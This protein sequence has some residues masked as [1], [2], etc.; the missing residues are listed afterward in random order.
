M[1][2]TRIRQSIASVQQGSNA[3]FISGLVVL[4]VILIGIPYN[5]KGVALFLLLLVPFLFGIRLARR[6][7]EQSIGYLLRNALAMGLTMALMVLLFM[8]L[9]NR[10]QAK[11]I[12]VRQYFYNVTTDT[13]EVLS[14]VPARELHPHPPTDPLTGQTQEVTYI[15]PATGEKA[16][17]EAPLT[18]PNDV[19]KKLLAQINLAEGKNT[20]EVLTPTQIRYRLTVEPPPAGQTDVNLQ[21]LK[22]QIEMLDRTN[23][24]RLTFDSSTGLHFRLGFDLNLVMGGFYGFL[25]TL[26]LSGALGAVITR[27]A[28][29][30]N[31]GQYRKQASVSLSA[32]PATHLLVLLLP[33]VLFGLLWLSIGRGQR[34]P[35]LSL[36]SR[37]QEVQLVI[38]FAIILLGMVAIRSAQ[39]N[40]WRQSYPVR[41]GL[42]AG[43]IAL[44]IVLGVWHIRDNQMYFIATSQHPNGSQT[45]SILAIVI[46]G[47]LVAVQNALS[48]RKPGRLEMQLAGSTTLVAVAIMPLFLNRYQNQVLTIV[49]INVLLGLGLNIVVGYAGMLDLGYVAFLALGA[50]TYAF[51]SS[52]ELKFD[53]TGKPLGLKYAGNDAR[54]V[55]LAGWVVI[56]VLVA[57]LVVT[58]GLRLW[59]S[60]RT[61]QRQTN[62]PGHPSLITLPERPS[63]GVSVL[64]VVIA[65]GTS[66][67]AASLLDGSALYKNL[68]GGVSPFLVGLVIG[69]LVSAMSGI[70]LGIPVLRLRSDYLAIVTL[71]FGEIIRLL[72]N[73]LREYTGGAQG[74]LQI[75]SALPADSF[76]SVTY[77]NMTYLVFVGAGLV[78][79]LSNRLRQARIGRAWNAVRSDEDIAQSMGINLVQTKLLAFAIGAGFAGLG[80]VLFAARQSNAI[81]TDFQ[82]NV[83]IQVLSLI[84]IGGM[85]SIPGVIIGAIALIGIPE[86]LRELETYRILVFGALLIVMVIIRPAGLLP[87]PPTQLRAR[88]RELVQQLDLYTHKEDQA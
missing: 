54:V 38:T 84:I 82:L 59:N 80:G 27:G 58:V 24:M 2:Q 87:E 73:N 6:L 46:A 47:V 26:I 12:D 1:L 7:H 13:M 42:C 50:Y 88:A 25:L 57:L 61:T 15:D 65:I 19:L 66:L 75:P 14:G 45:L 9:I 16:N 4:F 56:T 35:I 33:L 43:L 85:G 63:F 41:V 44:L 74:I 20:A 18:I 30:A 22:Y 69:V 28:F 51:L 81:P 71:G 77:L 60:R 40:D 62:D 52:N 55:Q 76:G 8:S 23:P 53:N 31:V 67:V 17:P 83:S 36:G 39:P 37:R 10:W 79:F 5:I 70:A 64:L 48:L 78:A 68:F 34:E 21:D 3:G 29:Q 49:G 11:G 86:I 72:F 32:N